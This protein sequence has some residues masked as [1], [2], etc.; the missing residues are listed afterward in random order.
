MMST[1]VQSIVHTKKGTLCRA[2]PGARIVRMVAMKLTPAARVPTP[3]TIRPS[4][5]KSV[6]AERAKVRSVKGALA[7]QPMAG[8]PPVAKL[9]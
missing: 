2:M 4:A 1:E 5:Q 6:A 8:A 9:K 7:N 3:V